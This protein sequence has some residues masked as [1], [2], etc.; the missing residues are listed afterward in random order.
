MIMTINYQII[1]NIKLRIGFGQ[2]QYP[3]G[4][5][6]P[7]GNDG[8]LMDSPVYDDAPGKEGPD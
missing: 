8:V 4:A 3:V 7:L 2:A 1:Q 6:R 5:Y